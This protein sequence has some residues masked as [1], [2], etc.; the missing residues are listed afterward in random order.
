VLGL[1]GKRA[2]VADGGSGIGRA[3]ARRAAS[4]SLRPT[5]R[6]RFGRT[7]GPQRCSHACGS[8]IDDT[9]RVARR[10]ANLAAPGGPPLEAALTCTF[11]ERTTGFEPATPTLARS[12]RCD[13]RGSRSRR[14][15]QYQRLPRA[16]T[17][18]RRPSGRRLGG[19]LCGSVR[20]ARRRSAMNRSVSWRLLRHEFVDYSVFRDLRARGLPSRRSGLAPSASRW[21]VRSRSVATS[22]MAI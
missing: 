18:P 17:V 8:S 15:V 21:M 7:R 9:G 10:L 19:K 22:S 16:D 12:G 1:E 11:V 14:I 3:T 5:G 20:G 6:R 4:Q 13:R 2:L